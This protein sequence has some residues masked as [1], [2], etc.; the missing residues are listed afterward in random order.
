MN[1]IVL[2]NRVHH[3]ARG[4]IPDCIPASTLSAVIANRELGLKPGLDPLQVHRDFC[5][6]QYALGRS[7]MDYNPTLRD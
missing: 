1:H 4:T 3:R 7:Y 6:R 5:D 2:R